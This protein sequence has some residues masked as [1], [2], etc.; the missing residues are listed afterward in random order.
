MGWRVALTGRQ[1]ATRRVPGALAPLPRPAPAFWAAAT[2]GLPLEC[3]GGPA[4]RRGH[5][6]N[7]PAPAGQ[8]ARR[9]AG[10]ADRLGV[11]AR[12]IR[13]RARQDLRP[14]GAVSRD[15]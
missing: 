7:L 14:A 3:L 4:A 11:A 6:G 9:R 13:R 1:P 10:P 8:R 12:P 5:G 15:L 2:P